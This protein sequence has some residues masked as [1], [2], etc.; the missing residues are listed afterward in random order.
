MNF[1]SEIRNKL[2]NIRP[3]VA[4]MRIWYATLFLKFIYFIL[5][6]QIGKFHVTI[7]TNSFEIN[8]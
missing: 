5:A 1:L 6:C 4:V 8:M 2:K 7:N 3:K